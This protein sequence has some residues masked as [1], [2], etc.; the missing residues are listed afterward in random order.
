[1]RPSVVLVGSTEIGRSLAPRVA[2][3][4]GTG[5][6]ADCTQL[7]YHDHTLTQIR[8]AFGGNIMARIVTP[9]HRPQ[10]ATV[11]YRIFDRA[12]PVANPDG[13]IIPCR[14]PGPVASAI[15]VVEAR[16]R[17]KQADISDAE[18]IVAGGRGVRNP[19]DM[20][21]IASLAEALGGEIAVTRP[22]AEAGYA[23]Q[24]RQI[25]LSGRTVKPRLMFAC[26]ISGA[27]QFQAGMNTA[28][29]IVAINTD[30][31]APIFDIAHFGIVGDLYE[32][33]PALVDAIKGGDTSC[34]AG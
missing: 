30:P 34:F 14:L 31:A 29:H 11:R 22:L 28:E 7:E 18:I 32:V 10:F 25:G 8:P 1:M 13:K 15:E 33:I 2:A 12:C 26:G 20:A 27:I 24:S 21:L 16:P 5:L 9:G 6:T 23:P 19:A 17:E 3:R 4:L